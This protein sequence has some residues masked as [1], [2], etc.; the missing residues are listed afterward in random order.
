MLRFMLSFT[1]LFR[2]FVTLLL[3]NRLS[4]GNLY[5][6]TLLPGLV[7]HLSV[8]HSVTFLIILCVALLFRSSHSVRHLDSAA[9]L[10]GLIPALF[11]PD[12]GAGGDATVA[13]TK[14]KYKSQHLHNCNMML[15]LRSNCDSPC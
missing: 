10:S 1:L 12:C 11:L 8:V 14:Q 13:T 6:V 4:P 2:Y 3:W 5:S 15:G 9:L 7:V